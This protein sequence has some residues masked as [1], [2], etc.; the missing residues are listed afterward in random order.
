MQTPRK[1]PLGLRMS[2]PAVDSVSSDAM[3]TRLVLIFAFCVGTIVAN[4]YYAQ[5]II[6]LIAPTLG[7]SPGVASLIVSL[8]QVGY[9]AGLF[10]LVPLGD[11]LENRR[12]IVVTVLMTAIALGLQATAR[13]PSIFLVASV[14]VGLTSVAV[15]MLVPFAAHLAPQESRG[16]IVGNVMGGL[17]T[18]LLL[19]RPISSVMTD[20][21]GWRAMF[22]AA[23][24][25]MLLVAGIVAACLPRRVPEAGL[26][27]GQLIASLIHLFRETTILRRRALYQACL[28]A[29]FSL[30]WTCVPIELARRHGLS[31]SQIALFALIGAAGVVAGPI[32]GRL[33]DA[34][35]SRFGTLLALWGTVGAFAVTAVSPQP[36]VAL[37]ALGAVA[38]DAC[39]QLNMVI[40]QRSIYQLPA[41]HRSRLNALYMTSIFVGGAVGS[42]LSSGLYDW[43]G[44]RAVGSVGALFAL[45]AAVMALKWERLSLE[46]QA[47]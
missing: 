46:P 41:A 10:L 6:E 1:S 16:R 27:Y 18:G 2:E 14:L 23:A 34:G 20:M 11:L 25:A 47:A 22:G 45:V 44:W 21:F 7:L 40:G 15:Q 4:L 28:F 38:L 31:Q 12:L 13:S 19:A 9:A 30:F 36:T 5:P 24:V 3:P 29:A 17:L 33:A 37:L 26:R 8:T 32:G 42:A 35:R 39:V 43:A